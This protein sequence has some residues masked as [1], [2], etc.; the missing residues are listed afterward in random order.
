MALPRW[1][2]APALVL[3][4]VLTL[5]ACGGGTSDAAGS[6]AQQQPSAAPSSASPA[7]F[8]QTDVRFTTMMLPHHM[9]AVRMSK[10]E[11]DKGGDPQ[12][13][14]LAKQILSAQEKEIATMRGFLQEFGVGEKPVPSDK[15]QRW[16][17]DFQDL[18]QAATPQQTDVVFL[19]NMMP[20]HASAVP[21]AQTEI[22]LGSY[23]PAMQLAQQIKTAQL[24]EIMTMKTMLR[25]RG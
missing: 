15:Q 2:T 23:A 4:P 22:D 10:V 17:R 12:V 6:A 11:I 13:V 18:Q 14:A 3:V 25:A 20:H 9:Q 16:D 19:T 7:P 8:N 5:T 21:M 24:E 1:I